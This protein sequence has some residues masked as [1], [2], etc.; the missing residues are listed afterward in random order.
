MRRYSY[1]CLV[2]APPPS[3]LRIN[4]TFCSC[5]M[6]L[7]GIFVFSKI[8]K[9]SPFSFGYGQ[10][11]KNGFAVSY[12]HRQSVHCSLESVSIPFWRL[13]PVLLRFVSRHN[14]VTISEIQFD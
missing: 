14:W 7:N 4:Q 5:E 12:P 9:M 11:S 10:T 8:V 1:L 2:H 3:K 13:P 6:Q